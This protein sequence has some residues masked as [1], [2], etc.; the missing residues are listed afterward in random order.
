MRKRLPG[1]IGASGSLEIGDVI[2]LI[3]PGRIVSS[4][5]ATPKTVSFRPC[6]RRGQ[7]YI[8]CSPDSVPKQDNQ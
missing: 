5:S 2:R 8:Y 7:H 3:E 4:D 1:I 6:H